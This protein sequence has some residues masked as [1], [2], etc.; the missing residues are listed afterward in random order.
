MA[1]LGD[2]DDPVD[3][4]SRPT[5]PDLVQ[6]DG[7]AERGLRWVIAVSVGGVASLRWF[8]GRGADRAKA[9][10]ETVLR[11]LTTPSQ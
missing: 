11:A 4:L 5:S 1:V 9:G 7:E 2:S 8:N 6:R 10:L 3:S